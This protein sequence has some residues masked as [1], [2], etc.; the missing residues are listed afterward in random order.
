LEE[1]SLVDKLVQFSSCTWDC[2]SVWGKIL[3]LAKA[4]CNLHKAA[5]V[6][7]WPSTFFS[8]WEHLHSL[9][10]QRGRCYTILLVSC[11]SLQS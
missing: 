3:V 10:S 8:H 11:S 6:S 1:Y 7:R 4:T 9:L 2:Y 5:V